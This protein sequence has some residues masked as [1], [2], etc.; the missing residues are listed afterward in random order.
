MYKQI[1][2]ETIDKYL[3]WLNQNQTVEVVTKHE[4]E[5][6]FIIVYYERNNFKG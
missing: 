5:N 6:G 2:F 4:V 3:S 1:F